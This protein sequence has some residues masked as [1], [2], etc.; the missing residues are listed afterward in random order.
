MQY[1]SVKEA[2]EQWAISIQMVRRYC[3]DNRIPGVI[4]RDGNW[5]IP[6]G[7]QK[8]LAKKELEKEP[9]PKKASLINKMRYEC[10][11]NNHFGYYEYIQV[12]LAYS[13]IRRLQRASRTYIN[14][15]GMSAT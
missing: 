10:K 3:K 8:P 9:P 6:E 15:E 13:S 1:I 14:D 4:L 5:C 7:A 12:N 11:K 2:A